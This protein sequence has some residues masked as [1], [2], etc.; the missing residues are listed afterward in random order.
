[1]SARPKSDFFNFSITLI[2]VPLLSLNNKSIA[3]TKG[4]P[5]LYVMIAVLNLFV[6]PSLRYDSELNSKGFVLNAASENC[7]VAEYWSSW[8]SYL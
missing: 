8:Y 2:T 1:M 5:E 3:V 7:E 4:P 6:T